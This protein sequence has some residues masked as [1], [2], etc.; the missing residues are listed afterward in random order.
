MGYVWLYFK[1]TEK[2]SEG[3]SNMLL[4]FKEIGLNFL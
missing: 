1:A 3:N 2:I 4:Y